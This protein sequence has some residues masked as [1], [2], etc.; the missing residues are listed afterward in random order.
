[1][2]PGGRSIFIFKGMSADEK[3]FRQRSD[4]KTVMNPIVGFQVVR[5]IIRA[6]TSIRDLLKD[7]KVSRG[8]TRAGASSSKEETIA[9]FF[10]SL[11]SSCF[12]F[13]LLL[14]LSPLQLCLC[15]SFVYRPH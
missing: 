2:K 5:S 4:M 13:A 15:A 11:I 1:M 3:G 10:L 8:L 12:Q 7:S 14:K 9:C 6:G